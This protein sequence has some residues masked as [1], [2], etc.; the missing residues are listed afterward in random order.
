MQQVDTTPKVNT[1]ANIASFDS[2][3]KIMTD[4][5]QNQ[6]DLPVAIQANQNAGSSQAEQNR[7]AVEA[8]LGTPTTVS[9]PTQTP[10][11]V[12]D[13]G[14]AG[15]GTAGGTGNGNDNANGNANDN[16]G[17]T[18]G[19][20]NAGGAAGNGNGNG[21]ANGNGNGRGRNRGKNNGDANAK[22]RRAVGPGKRF[23]VVDPD[24]DGA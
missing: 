15:G 4:V 22:R 1:P 23:V 13:G 9:A 17:A 19:N 21:N 11:V 10:E 3:D 2:M 8:I 14:Q 20:G 18:T 24:E 6:K 12:F 16:G 5:A 7:A